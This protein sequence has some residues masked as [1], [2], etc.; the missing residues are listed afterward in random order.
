MPH[1]SAPL[2]PAEATVLLS[3]NT[4]RPIRAIKATLLLMLATGVLRIEETPKR[5]VFRT[6]TIAH[7]RVAAAPTNP[8]PEIAALIGVVRA[9]Q[10]DGGKITD[11]VALCEATFGSNCEKFTMQF[12]V[13]ALIA[14]GLLVKKKLWLFHT[15]RL[16]PAGQQLQA[17]LKSDLFR[18]KDAARLL[19]SDPAKAAALAATLGPAIFLHDKLVRKF[20]PLADA[21]RATKGG[22]GGDAGFY[23]DG[24]SHHAG[25]FGFG[26]FDLG[27]F[28][29]G[30]FD[31]GA[32]GSAIDS[33]D[34]GFGDSG[35]GHDGGGGG[36]H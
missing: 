14:R 5:G 11:V 6:R 21:V 4:V 17:Q 22:G 20:K 1:I 9:A 35:G 8:P 10:V 13:P 7:L 29:L 34:S 12:V 27:S 28:D 18:A 15:F 26:N 2:S 25:G 23:D 33:F 24:G 36:H 3:P 32:L 19:K 31:F 30:G 16:T